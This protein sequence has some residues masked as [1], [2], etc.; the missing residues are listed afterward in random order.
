M[1]MALALTLLTTLAPVAQAQSG[2][3]KSTGVTAQT[4]RGPAQSLQV[5]LPIVNLSGELC[6][7]IEKNLGG[8]ASLA[9]EVMSKKGFEEIPEERQTETGESR[10][11]RGRGASLMMSRYSDSSRMAGFYWGMGLGFREEDVSWKVRP[12]PRDPAYR[13]QSRETPSLVTHA[14]RMTGTTGHGRLG[15]RYVGHDVPFSIGAYLGFRHFQA[16]VADNM[17]QTG[18]T[19]ADEPPLTALSDREREKLR[20]VYATRPETGLEV[21]FSF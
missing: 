10:M 6:G 18:E 19:P 1:R 9:L 2:G 11:S 7:H 16:K 17:D 12:N 15:Y 21:G 20:R 3:R 13:S 8:H 4:S 14:A 5:S